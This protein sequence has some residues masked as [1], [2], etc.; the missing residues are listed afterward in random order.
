MHVYVCICIYA[1]ADRHTADRPTNRPIFA[2]MTLHHHS[3]RSRSLG[4]SV[5][6]VYDFSYRMLRLAGRMDSWMDEWFWYGSVSVCCCGLTGCFQPTT[7][8]ACCRPLRRMEWNGLWAF[9]GSLTDVRQES[10]RTNDNYVLTYVWTQHSYGRVVVGATRSLAMV[11]TKNDM[12]KMLGFA[13]FGP[14]RTQPR[15]SIWGR[16]QVIEN[17]QER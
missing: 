9:G 16:S 2:Q 5:V 13:T 4:R 12:M 10:L 6:Y 7:T 11:P 15:P 8:I 3:K 14:N 1:F 17:I